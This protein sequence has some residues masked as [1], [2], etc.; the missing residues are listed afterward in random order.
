MCEEP[1]QVEK[2]NKH[3]DRPSS[4]TKSPNLTKLLY[5]EVV[6]EFCDS[7]VDIVGIC[8]VGGRF[9]TRRVVSIFV[10][11]HDTLNLCLCGPLLS[12]FCSDFLDELSFRRCLKIYRGGDHCSLLTK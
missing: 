3:V 10:F 4:S 11:Q 1:S 9:F 6:K 5:V 12:L 2:D 8:R 7:R